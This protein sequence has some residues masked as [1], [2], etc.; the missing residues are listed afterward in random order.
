MKR[1]LIIGDHEVIMYECGIFR[2]SEIGRINWIGGKEYDFHRIDAFRV[3]E[4]YRKQG[5]GKSMLDGLINVVK[6]CSGNII[7]VYPNSEQ[8]EG[9]SIVENELL[10]KIYEC[11]GF[12]LVNPNANRHKPNNKMTIKF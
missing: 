10:Y 8:Y 6:S 1:K 2:K 5:I 12:E 9:E 3:K 11:M 4:R 7:E